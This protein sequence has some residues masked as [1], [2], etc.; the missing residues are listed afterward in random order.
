MVQYICILD[1]TPA[2]PDIEPIRIGNSRPGCRRG[3]GIASAGGHSA[4]ALP[5]FCHKIRIGTGRGNIRPNGDGGSR[6][7]PAKGRAARNTG[8]HWKKHIQKHIN[9]VVIHIRERGWGGIW[10]L[11][12]IWQNGKNLFG[13]LVW[14]KLK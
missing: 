10:N 4:R 14:L 5:K 11:C 7:F 9:I 6:H 8:K 1:A 2:R 13:L 3:R 12:E